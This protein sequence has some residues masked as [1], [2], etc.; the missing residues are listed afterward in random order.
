VVVVH[1]SNHCSSFSIG[2]GNFSVWEFS[3]NPVYFCCYDYFAANDPMSIHII[4]FSLE[5]PYEI[6]LNKV[7]FWLSFLKP[8]IPIEEHVGEQSPRSVSVLCPL[9]SS[10]HCPDLPPMWPHQTPRCGL[11]P[12]SIPL[13]DVHAGKLPGAPPGIVSW[14]AFCVLT[15]APAPK[16]GS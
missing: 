6:Q 7:I 10:C 2:V 11:L 1:D 14:G 15:Y 4:L 3:G 13:R 5:E 9:L 8:L 12:F 16:A